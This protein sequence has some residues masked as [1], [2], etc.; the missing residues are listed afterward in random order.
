MH[1]TM[2][3][4]NSEIKYLMLSTVLCVLQMYCTLW[5]HISSSELLLLERCLA[6][7]SV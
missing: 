4:D 5:L 6:V 7:E 2:K 3:L 1:E